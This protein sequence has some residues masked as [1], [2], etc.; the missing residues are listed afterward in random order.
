MAIVPWLAPWDQGLP[1]PFVPTQPP[2]PPLARPTLSPALPSS[3]HRPS[4]SSKEPFAETSTVVPAAAPIVNLGTSVTN[5]IVE[6]TILVPSALKHKACNPAPLRLNPPSIPV[7][8]INLTA[9]LKHHPDQQY[10]ASLLQDLQWGCNIGYTGPRLARITPNLRSAHLHPEAISAALAK[11]VSNGHTAGPFL[12]PPIPNLQCSPL[13]QE[14]WHLAHHHGP[15][16]PS[17]F[18]N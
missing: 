1:S 18:F 15:L 4:H 6:E 11:E 16:S 12:S 8:I 7:N 13:A 10:T 2:Q 9:E 14:G 17:R 5:Q 3:Q